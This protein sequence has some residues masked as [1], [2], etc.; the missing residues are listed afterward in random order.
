MKLD[1]DPFPVNMNMVELEEKKV[2]VRPSQAKTTK[3]KEVVIGE[4]QPLRM[5]KP[6]SLK[7][8]QWQKNE[9]GGGGGGQAATPPKDHLQ[10][11]HGQVQRRQGRH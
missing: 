5:I 1:K 8:S 7:D 11:P 9:G 6:R 3:G 2:L 10:H 4:E